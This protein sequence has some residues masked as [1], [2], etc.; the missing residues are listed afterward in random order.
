MRLSLNETRRE[1]FP[2]RSFWSISRILI[3]FQCVI[4]SSSFLLTRPAFSPTI[5]LYA[6]KL[7]Q[8]SD[9]KNATSV[10]ASDRSRT[11]ND[12]NTESSRD[13]ASHVT[14][15]PTIP[16]LYSLRHALQVQENVVSRRNEQRVVGHRGA[17]Y[18][19]LE[20][21]REAFLRCVDLGCDGVELDVF[22]LRD[23]ES[24]DPVVVVFHGGGS[25][26]IPGDLSDYCL[27]QQGVSILDLSY[28]QSQ[29][30]VFN[31]NHPEFA[32]QRY[33]IEK[34]RIPTLEEVLLDLKGT[35]LQVKIELKGHGTVEPT[36][37]LVERLR[38]E[39]QCAYSCFDHEQI[40]KLRQLRPERDM[41]PTAALFD[42][43][44]PDDFIEIANNCGATEIH[45]QY[46]TCTV[47]RIN[48][49]RQAGMR[50]MAWFRGPVG[51][52]EDVKTRYLD[53]GNEDDR[54]YEAVLDTGVDEL[55]VNKP[56]ILINILHRR[57]QATTA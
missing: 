30:L 47:E 18:D 32:C 31:P 50:S 4:P 44:L 8:I 42:R 43:D 45:L 11:I 7:P 24:D 29:K 5:Q 26:Q 57:R 2:F 33:L 22:A 37:A 36:L 20:N 40:R 34:A 38:M 10:T 41:Y 12:D 6:E 56:D 55:C 17:L 3:C 49:I 35:A 28:Q 23:E 46:D 19:A 25:D 54:C 51:M 39:N 21:T 9:S 15:T 52:A 13:V 53:V 14:V 16:E 1:F 48:A 27:G